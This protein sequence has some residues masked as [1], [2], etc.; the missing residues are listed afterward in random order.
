MT[1]KEV[2]AKIIK[3]EVLTDE[4]KKY[5]E[6]LEDPEAVNAAQAN[7]AA[8][9]TKLQQDLQAATAAKEAAEKALKDAAQ[10]DLPEVDQLRTQVEELNKTITT[11][12]GERDSANADLAKLKRST[13]LSTLA[14]KYGT[15]ADYLD[16]K[17]SKDSKLNI[18][19]DSA[20][21]NFIAEAKK[22]EPAFFKAE[23]K[24][25]PAPQPKPADNPPAPAATGSI[26]SQAI[27]SLRNSN[28]K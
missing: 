14:A 23:S 20:V 16:F 25:G 6:G 24:P 27:N 13:R 18:E 8:E 3:G 21:E 2:V 1:L 11:L 9:L 15:S 12:T 10:K 22:A 26:L 28:S 5:L 7:A 17:F 19:D 4:E